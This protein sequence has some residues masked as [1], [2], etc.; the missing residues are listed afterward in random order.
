MKRLFLISDDNDFSEWIVDELAE[1]GRFTRSIDSFD[2]FIPQWSASQ[3]ADYIIFTDSVVTSDENLLRIYRAI[4]KESPETVFLFIHHRDE[5]DLTKLLVAEGNLCVSYN[6]LEAGLMDSLI[7]QHV[8]RE[9]MPIIQKQLTEENLRVSKTNF[10]I[11]EKSKFPQQLEEVTEVFIDINERSNSIDGNKDELL[12][13]D[14]LPGKQAEVLEHNTPNDETEVKEFKPQK[15]RSSAEQKEKL[16]RIK[17]RII[18]EEKIITIHVPVHYN[19]KLISIVSLYPRAGSTFVTSNFARMLGENKVP[20]AVLEPVIE[21]IGSTYYE[22]MHGEVNAPKNWVSYAEQIKQSG[23]VHQ[24]NIWSSHGVTWIPSGLEPIKE[25]NEENN[26]KL[27][28]SAN[29]FPVTICDI[30]SRYND[31]NCKKFMSIS[32]EIWIVVDGDPVALN[33]HY[34]TIDKLKEEYDTKTIRI[35]GNRWNQYINNSEWKEAVLLPILTHIPDLGNIVLKQMWDGKMAWDD[36]KIKNILALPFKPMVRAVVAKEMY[37]MMKKNYGLSS[38]WKNII[39]H[40]KNL[41][42]ESKARK[43]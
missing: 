32:D 22:L 36:M 41:D 5:N 21:N 19:S 39:K 11:Q 4:R 26:L 27:L 7:K 3:G 12:S 16:A 37:N 24:D 42:D 33:Q 18:I 31:H 25:W 1:T 13:G 15:K 10:E 9:S 6:E 29:R 14:M 34:K 20:V 35:I 8:T 23:S 28:L 40:I 43:M 30:S 2:F 17:E 38:K